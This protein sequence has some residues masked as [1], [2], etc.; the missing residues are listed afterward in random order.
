M[1]LRWALCSAENYI[2]ASLDV[3]L[4]SIG[5]AQN[6]FWA[7]WETNMYLR[8]HLRWFV[9]WNYACIKSFFL[10]WFLGIT[11]SCSS[12]VILHWLCQSRNRIDVVAL[13][14]TFP[15]DLVFIIFFF[16]NCSSVNRYYINLLLLLTTKCMVKN[17]G[18]CTYW[19]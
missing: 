10:K 3:F 2:G 16:V 13:S 14:C 15:T 11:Y 8:K 5:A 12:T 9:S 4:S 7:V 6:P 18:V 17:S 1:Y 19:W